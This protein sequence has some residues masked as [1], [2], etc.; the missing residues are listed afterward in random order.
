MPLCPFSSCDIFGGKTKKDKLPTAGM[1]TVTH[2]FAVRSIT[3]IFRKWRRYHGN[4][5]SRSPVPE[6]EGIKSPTKKILIIN[7]SLLEEHSLVG[8]LSTEITEIESRLG[9]SSPGRRTAN[10]RSRSNSFTSR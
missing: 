2:E 6:I 5:R 3:R 10:S 8:D 9:S 1:G 4:E 7:N